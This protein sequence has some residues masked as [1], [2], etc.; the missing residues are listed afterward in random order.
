VQK[1]EEAGK[2]LPCSCRISIADP[3][4]VNADPDPTF[5]LA[6][7]LND[8]DPDELEYRYLDIQVESQPN[9]TSEMNDY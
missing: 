8:A 3:Q 7:L 4:H 6:G 2:F 5:F 9:D 1:R